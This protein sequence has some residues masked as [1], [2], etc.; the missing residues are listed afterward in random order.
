MAKLNLTHYCIKHFVR[1][2][3]GSCFVFNE[4]HLLFSPIWTDARTSLP[5]SEVDHIQTWICCFFLSVFISCAFSWTC[6]FSGSSH[7]TVGNVCWQ[8]SSDVTS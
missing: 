2:G 1:V 4:Y 5:N 7:W 6:A 8:E 3:E